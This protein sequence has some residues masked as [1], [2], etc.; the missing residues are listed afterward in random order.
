MEET[1]GQPLSV[2]TISQKCGVS[3][4]HLQTLFQK[5]FGAPP[6]LHYLAL[7][8]NV[9]RRNVIETDNELAAI[10]TQTGFNSP[11]AFSRAYRAQFS[12]SPSETRRRAV[13]TR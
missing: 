2:E 11:A 9:A 12:E 8:L 7:R 10:A 13:A 1:V 4:R 3:A 5:S 6:N